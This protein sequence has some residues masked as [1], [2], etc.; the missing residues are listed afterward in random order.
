LGATQNTNSPLNHHRHSYSNYSQ[1]NEKITSN[2]TLSQLTLLQNSGRK[3]HQIVAF[4]FG[5]SAL[6]YETVQQMRSDLQNPNA[7]AEG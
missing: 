3:P 6:A 7:L 1:E 2:L 4:G 5:N